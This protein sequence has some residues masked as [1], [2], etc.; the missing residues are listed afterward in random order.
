MKQSTAHL[1]QTSRQSRPP[2]SLKLP[3]GPK[4]RT[5]GKD[6]AR[7]Q[8]ATILAPTP[9]RNDGRSCE[10]LSVEG[11]RAYAVAFA[12]SFGAV[13]LGNPS[14]VLGERFRRPSEKCSA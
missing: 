3:A 1:I 12:F 6:R 8:S 5:A 11:L 2:A 9:R 14:S 4:M 13:N 10:V 7:M